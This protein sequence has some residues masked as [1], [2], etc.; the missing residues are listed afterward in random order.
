MLATWVNFQSSEMSLKEL[1][2]RPIYSRF[3]R[4]VISVGIDP[5][6]VL[7]LRSSFWR[8]VQ[9]P[10]VVGIDPSNIL[11]LR[12]SKV[13][14]VAEAKG[15]W[16]GPK[17]LSGVLDMPSGNKGSEV[18]EMTCFFSKSRREPIIPNV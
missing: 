14:D 8:D 11:F 9:R 3:D 2:A 12:S 7:L 15:G 6:S 5:S 13:R 16:N 18:L 17:K 1:F 10:R 4:L